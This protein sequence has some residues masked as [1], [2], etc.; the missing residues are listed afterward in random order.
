[1]RRLRWGVAGLITLGLAAL[2]TWELETSE[3]QSLVISRY[4]AGIDHWLASGATPAPPRH[5][6]PGPV[7]RRAGY[8]DLPELL[9][10]LERQG[11]AIVAQAR[12]SA[13]FE[14]ALDKGLFPIYFEKAQTG[15][16]ILDRDARRIFAYEYPE[17]VLPE[18]EFI[19]PLLV[20]SLLFIENG[21]LLNAERPYRNPAVEWDRLGAVALRVGRRSLGDGV[22][23]PG[24]STL[25]TQLEKF[26]HSPGGVTQTPAEKSRQ[27]ASASVRAYLDGRTTLGAQRRIV[28]DYL[29]GLP[30]AAIPN[31]GEIHG[32]LDGLRL[33]YD[34]GV[35]ELELL[36]EPISEDQLFRAA[37]VYR[38]ALS[39]I[40]AT[41]RP[42]F[43]LA[44]LEGSDDLTRLC[45]VY[46]KLLEQQRVIPAALGRALREVRLVQRRQAPAVQRTAFVEQKAAN[47]DNTFDRAAPTV[48]ERD[49]VRYHEQRIPFAREVIED[50]QHPLRANY[51]GRFADQEGEVFV[52]RFHR[53]HAGLTPVES[54]SAVLGS[55]ASSRLRAGR[56]Y[57]AVLPEASASDLGA[58]LATRTADEP[59]A[60]H[61]IEALYRRLLS[62]NFGLSDVAYLV[63]AHPLELWVARYL[64][65]Y[66]GAPVS[67]AVQA[68]A[69]ARQEAYRWL[70]RTRRKALQD[71]RIRT[72]LEAE[73]FA[74]VHLSWQRLGYPFSSLVPSYATAIGSSGDTPEALAE[75]LGVIV[76]DGIRRPFTSIAALRFAQHT[77]F[78]T[79]LRR[80]IPGSARALSPAVVRAVKAALADVIASGTGRRVR[81]VVVAADG[82]PRPIGGKTGTGDNQHVSVDTRGGRVAS[83]ARNRTAT[84]VFFIEN[85]FGV[86]TAYVEGPEAADFAFTSALPAQVLRHLAPTLEPLFLREDVVAPLIATRDPPATTSA[87]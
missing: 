31:Q 4:A 3:L 84:L 32:W 79:H 55:G 5:P 29:N 48:H 74:M 8:S 80:E 64:A 65:R 28:I 58:V 41:R 9:P 66:P 77:P 68:G 69:E 50:P 40:L 83:Y 44:S 22:A 57:L 53:K 46:S 26:R 75:L 27:M 70:Q 87:F 47:F 13:R 76:N 14:N 37:Y 33:W 52:R 20:R 72:V 43:Y 1:M 10:R 35:N 11:F 42:A 56:V 24:A 86:L 23:V 38:A 67:Q 17:R 45:D 85:H 82:A 18:F 6:L 71:E 81:D 73:A 21:E 15:L 61:E 25:A 78:E 12:V 2:L 60:Q 49:I 7:D 59:L 39:L 51:L 62:D 63:G 30:L 54:V 34:I 19:P 16:E 36:R